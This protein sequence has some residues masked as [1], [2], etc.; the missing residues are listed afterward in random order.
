MRKV[1]FARQSGISSSPPAARPLTLPEPIWKHWRNSAAVDI[2]M[3]SSE[4]QRILL[5]AGSWRFRLAGCKP[6]ARVFPLIDARDQP[7]I[8][9]DAFE[10]I[11]RESVF[12]SLVE[13]MEETGGKP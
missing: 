7:L 11:I 5:M 4:C 10:Y 12:S 3:Y 1:F 8:H 2:G 9:D 6:D 13:L